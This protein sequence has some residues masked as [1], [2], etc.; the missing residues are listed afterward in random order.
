MATAILPAGTY[1]IGDPCYIVPNDS[2]LWDDILT[3]TDYFANPYEVGETIMLCACSTAYGDGVY[4]G[5]DG[6]QYSVDAGVIGAF[7]VDCE[8][9][10]VPESAN[11][12][13]TIYT[14]DTE[15][16]VTSDIR[17][18][19]HIGHISIDTCGDGNDDDGEEDWED[20]DAIHIW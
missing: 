7:N 16:E 10:E 8:G 11:N 17:G 6:R 20:E 4:P 13:G 2:D 9:V 15:F 3:S 12:L 18:V 1:F 19:I 14:F 5:S